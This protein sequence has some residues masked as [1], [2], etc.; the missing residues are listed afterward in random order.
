MTRDAQCPFP[1]RAKQAG[2]G[3]KKWDLH[4]KWDCTGNSSETFQNHP[5][6]GSITRSFAAI[7]AGGRATHERDHR[8]NHGGA[9]NEVGALLEQVSADFAQRHLHLWQRFMERFEQLRELLPE[10]E[11]FSDSAAAPDRL[12]LSGGIL[13]GIGCAVQPIDGAAP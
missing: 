6:T 10:G 12:L 3:G 13:A 1:R 5:E 11:R 9:G 8:K 4:G 7:R 2:P